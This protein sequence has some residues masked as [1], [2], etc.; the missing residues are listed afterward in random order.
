MSFLDF[1]INEKTFKGVIIVFLFLIFL[2]TLIVLIQYGVLK[3]INIKSEDIVADENLLE[4]GVVYELGNKMV[5]VSGFA[6]K[7]GQKIEYFDS[8]F[9]LRNNDTGKMYKMRTDMEKKPDFMTIDGQYDCS[10]AG[11]RAQSFLL[12]LNKGTYSICILY[13]NDGE[14]IFTDTGV[15][16]EVK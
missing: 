15:E 7:K 4:K 1:E 16:F 14:N 2:F 13:N 3:P 11:M 10:N 6:Y 5:K 9:V 8:S 12:G